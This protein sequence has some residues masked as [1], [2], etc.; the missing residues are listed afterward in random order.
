MQIKE[1]IIGGLN[2]ELPC[3][4]RKQIQTKLLQQ[5]DLTENSE[6]KYQLPEQKILL[7]QFK[8]GDTCFR[9]L[10]ALS[11]D[12][13][14]NAL[15]F[16]HDLGCPI[17]VENQVFQVQMFAPP[18]RFI[19]CV[20]G[21]LVY[22]IR[23]SSFE[24]S[25]EILYNIE[26]L[27]CMRGAP[28]LANLV[29][30]VVDA[31]REYFKSYLIKYS[32]TRGRIDRIAEDSSISWDRR[33]KWAE[34]LVETVADLHSKGFVAGM[35]CT[36]RIPMITDSS[37]NVQ[38]FD[39][40]KKFVMGR[41]LGGYYPP[42][43]HHLWEASPATSESKCPDI[44]SKADIFHLGVMLWTLAS[45]QRMWKSLVCTRVDCNRA[46]FCRNESH[47]EPNTLAPLS[48]SIPQFYKDVVDSCV[49]RRPGDRPAARDLLA[50]FA[51]ER[52]RQTA[53]LKTTSII[54]SAGCDDVRA[55]EEN[56]LANISC[57]ICGKGHLQQTT[58]FHC[59]VCAFNDFDICQQCYDRGEHCYDSEHLLVEIEKNGV[60]VAVRKYHSCP[61]IG[62][63]GRTVLEI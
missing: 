20:N 19:S 39:F 37:D 18:N 33:Q 48:A 2:S 31:N 52:Q 10:D 28:G 60:F 41:T 57:S 63:G 16:V 47:A 62:L 38:F 24:P 11:N 35:I 50:R 42:E 43:Y 22:E 30:I 4:L 6:F 51:R 5:D 59:H 44:T 55:L 8:G 54:N 26:L 12:P 17:Y 36:Y 56:K 3:S 1:N 14:Q 27:H 32:K 15:A 49:S 53:H 46:S 58:F 21:V 25:A 34:Q 7:E 61:R 9:R 45:G 29:G 23:L 40:K 13:H